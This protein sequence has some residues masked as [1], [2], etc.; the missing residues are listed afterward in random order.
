M[1]GRKIRLF[2]VINI[3]LLLMLTFACIY[4]L[5]YTVIASFSDYIPVATGK[6]SFWPVDFTTLAYEAVFEN[7]EIWSGYLN[8]IIYTVCGT[9]FN[10]FL[11][12]PTAYVMSRKRMFGHTL[13]TWFF[14]IT[15]YFSGGMVPTYLLYKTLNLVNNPMIMIVTGGLSVYN[16][17]VARTYFS[18]SI[19]E[20]LFESVRID[21]GSE[22]DQFFRI[23]LPLAKPV[24][25]VITLYYAV[26]HWNSYFNAMMYLS[27]K[28][29][30]PLALVLRRI[31]I[32][33]ESVV[34][35]DLLANMDVRI[36]EDLTQKA[37]MAVVMKYAL[38]LISSLPLLIA[39]PFVQ[40]Y[41]VKGV[42][43]G[44]VKG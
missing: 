25:A 36:L 10:L 39:Y 14:L 15:M 17:I 3:T 29:Y 30:H 43:I 33:N 20:S 21:G 7:Q 41:F 28:K 23:A 26:G 12:I 9:L 40:K 32:L 44:S 2:D 35:D 31:L 18:S 24:L 16:M 13:F 38:V 27:N 42:M 1:K 11:T 5:Y 22:F 19:P 4:P 8:T 34:S 37:N 6:I